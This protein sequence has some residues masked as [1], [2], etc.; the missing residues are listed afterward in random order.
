LEKLVAGRQTHSGHDDY[1][2][3][4]GGEYYAPRDPP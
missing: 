3:R 2:G 1:G 4:D